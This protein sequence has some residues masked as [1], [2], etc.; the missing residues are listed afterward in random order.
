[1]SWILKWEAK[2][3]Y[4]RLWELVWEKNWDWKWVWYICWD[5][6]RQQ[7]IDIIEAL[8]QDLDARAPPHSLFT[9]TAAHNLFNLVLHLSSY[10][11]PSSSSLCAHSS[12]TITQHQHQLCMCASIWILDHLYL[13][14]EERKMGCLSGMP[15]AFNQNIQEYNLWAEILLLQIALLGGYNRVSNPSMRKRG[16]LLESWHE[17]LRTVPHLTVFMRNRD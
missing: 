1:M 7:W 13:V 4:S 10:W 8:S 6:V 2:A 9:A 3:G 11:Q 15:M 5:R 16:L 14:A 12:L 17:A